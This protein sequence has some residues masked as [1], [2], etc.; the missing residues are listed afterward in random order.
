MTR[1]D[2]MPPLPSDDDEDSV[3][4]PGMLLTPEEFERFKAS[5]S[6]REEQDPQEEEQRDS[7]SPEISPQ[8]D[9]IKD[10][11][12]DE[13]GEEV[14]EDEEGEEEQDGQQRHV[15]SYGNDPQPLV[16]LVDGAEGGNC[17]FPSSATQNNTFSIA[18]SALHFPSYQQQHHHHHHHLHNL[19]SQ[20]SDNSMPSSLSFPSPFKWLNPNNSATVMGAS[21][22]SISRNTSQRRSARLVK[23]DEL[24]SLCRDDGSITTEPLIREDLAYLVQ[25]SLPVR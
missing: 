3:S 4:N 12:E 6:N 25:K 10:E 9:A 8:D 24:V 21:S 20:N 15:D 2:G 1:A 17:S 11:S 22:R 18:R 23:F 16:E 7:L 13:E 14:E 19:T 5:N